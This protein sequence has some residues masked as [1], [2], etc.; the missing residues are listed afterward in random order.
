[1]VT[2]EE[3]LQGKATIIKDKEYLT[4]AEYVQPFLDIVTPFV[5][6]F[7]IQVK[8][9]SQITIG[10]NKEDITYN[11]VLIQGLLPSSNDYDN[12]K[13]VV[14]FL[15]GLDAKKPVA[16]TYRGYLNM[17]CTNLS[18]FN[19]QWIHVQEISTE[20]ELNYSITELLGLANN[21]KN[22]IKELKET[23]IDRDMI[24]DHLGRW[25]DF[26]LTQ[27]YFN[28]V[29]GVKVPPTMPITG[30]KNVFLNKKSKYYVSDIEEVSLF[31]LHEAMT[32]V[33][34]DDKKDIINRYEKTMLVNQMIDLVKESL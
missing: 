19:P 20:K 30:Y 29:H 17:A 33:I 1:M 7:T 21:F 2:L 6:E 25:V 3:L 12:H 32:Q 4:T 10:A 8:T 34:T 13:E 5:D 27:E 11:R 31:D 24:Y 28:G 9:P 22:E 16:K 26:C 23:F 15:Y 18:V 14:G